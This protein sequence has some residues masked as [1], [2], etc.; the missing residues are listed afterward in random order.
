MTPLYTDELAA[1]ICTRLANGETLSAICRE[2]GMPATRTVREWAKANKA[3]GTAYSDA[4]EAGCHA[5]L[6]ETLEIADNKDEPAESRK[7]RIWTRHE[8]AARKRPDLFGKQVKLEHTGANGGPMKHEETV[9]I[10]PGEA[11]R[12]L[13]NPDA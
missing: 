8:L 11:Y 10:E 5:L 6:D 9:A 7:I 12:R 13:L 4:M 1:E 2:D 3:F